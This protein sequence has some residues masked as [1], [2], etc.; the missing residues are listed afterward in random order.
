MGSQPGGMSS[1][2]L[3]RE[4]LVR[5]FREADASVRYMASRHFFSS[6]RAR[7]MAPGPTPRRRA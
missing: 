4:E 3:D 6:V 1:R 5:A 2:K 7:Y